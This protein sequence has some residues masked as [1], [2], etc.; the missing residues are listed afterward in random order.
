M[1]H[2]DTCL[3]G[4]DISEHELRVVQVNVR[5]GKCSIARAGR[6]PMPEGAFVGRHVTH[7][8]A[9]S[10]ALR[11]LLDEVG[12]DKSAQAVL[13]VSSDRLTLRNMALPAVPEEELATV[14]AGEVDHFG[15]VQSKG[16]AYG[17]VR[18]LPPT[19]DP[20]DNPTYVTVMA[21]EEGVVSPLREVAERANLHISALEPSA[22]AMMR[23]VSLATPPTGTA[24]TLV[25]GGDNTDAV[26]FINGE[27]AAYR[28]MEIGS[29][30][31]IDAEK[32]AN[33]ASL[34]AVGGQAPEVGAYECLNE[35]AVDKLALE[36]R[37]TIEYLQREFPNFAAL[38]RIQIVTDIPEI[39]PLARILTERF[40]VTTSIVLPPV[41][42]SDSPSAV[43]EM[44]GISGIRYATAYGL[45][46]YN[47]PQAGSHVPKLDLFS[48]QRTAAVNEATKRNFA[49]SIV[50]SLFA[51]VAGIVGYW[52]YSQ[53]ISKIDGLVRTTSAQTATVNGLIDRTIEERANQAKQ[54]RA[55]RR[56]GVPVGAMMDYIVGS[57]EPG[58]G[59]TSVSIAPDLR[60]TIS[61]EALDEAS[62][63]RT[64]QN[65]QR[66][67]VIK[68]L[69]I[70][71]F[72]RV[73]SEA[74]NG[75]RFQLSG[76][77]VT[78][79]RVKLPT[80]VSR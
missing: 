20:A 5:G 78:M 40:G 4:I 54:Y 59:L 6:T 51:I 68:G 34:V 42:E 1:F 46:M 47:A 58:V 7:A 61:G 30:T 14:V 52:L 22:L 36:A 18:L 12:V 69:M 53:Q 31:L 3:L 65:L 9:L 76:Q 60:V 63:I 74:V 37:R 29:I 8:G 55:L 19:R 26:F 75:I 67:P 39:E 80:E 57:L 38:D 48:T 62:V 35:G 11:N 24:F 32:L 64:T 71:S 45:A 23:T 77:T 73:T 10:L 41:T 72:A 17:F 25:I 28:R 79:D 66:S 56:E 50:V 21:V 33:S 13:N 2:R 16:G 27:L 44:T 70:N 49:G 15:M 43:V